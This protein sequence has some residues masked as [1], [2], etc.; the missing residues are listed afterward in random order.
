MIAAAF[1]LCLLIHLGFLAWSFAFPRP[2]SARLWFLRLMLFGMAYDNLVLALGNVGAGASWYAAASHARFALHAAILPLLIPFALSAM[3]AC[4]IPFA[5]RRGVAACCWL[6]VAAAWSYGLWQDLGG[7]ELKPREVFGHL[8]LASADALPPLATIG[9]NLLAMLC[10]FFVWRRAG[11]SP[12][13]LGSLFIFL[14]NGA[15]G[16]LPWSIL[17]GNG[18]EVAFAL[19]LLLTERFLLRLE[20]RA[21]FMADP[22]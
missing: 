3:R 17:A 8:R 10:A 13:F 15:T 19:C 7:L 12:F 18:A 1:A 20:K 11:W 5:G 14:V 16:G 21:A 6:V 9:A 4:A 2:A 22:P